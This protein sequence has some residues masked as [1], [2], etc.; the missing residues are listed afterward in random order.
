MYMPESVR[1]TLADRIAFLTDGK[2]WSELQSK[3]GID[4]IIG[5]RRLTLETAFGPSGVKAYEMWGTKKD[6]KGLYVR[7]AV[8]YHSIGN[9]GTF[10]EHGQP[11]IVEEELKGNPTQQAKT[12][13]ERLHKKHDK[14]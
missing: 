3:L 7:A 2:Y 13:L 6:E 8:A 5:K 10:D 4:K 11:I 12:L 1:V 14:V 9:E